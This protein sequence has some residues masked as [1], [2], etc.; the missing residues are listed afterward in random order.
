[1]GP[2][3]RLFVWETAT[4]G[5]Y[6]LVLFTPGAVGKR[7]YPLPLTLFILEEISSRIFIT[8]YRVCVDV[9]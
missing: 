2:V 7:F 9:S 5:T 6:F 8:L 4:S 3:L 1:M